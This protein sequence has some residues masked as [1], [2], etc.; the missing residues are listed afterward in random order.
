MKSKGSIAREKKLYGG[1][2]QSH[3]CGSTYLE[4]R[5]KC[6]LSPGPGNGTNSLLGFLI[7]V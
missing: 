2:D 6:Y 4:A 3:L 5:C 7:E 1:S